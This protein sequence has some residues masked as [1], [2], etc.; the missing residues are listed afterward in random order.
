MDLVDNQPKIASTVADTRCRNCGAFV[1]PQFSRV[2]GNN[3]NEVYGC[4]DCMTAT[5]IKD[6][7]ANGREN[8]H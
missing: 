7:H 1:T 8:P 5:K 2:F 3:Q 4:F 6:G